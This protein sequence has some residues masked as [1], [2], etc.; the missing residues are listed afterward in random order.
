MKILARSLLQ[1]LNERLEIDLE[2]ND[3]IFRQILTAMKYMHENGIAHRD[4][5]PANILL[6]P[7]LTVKLIDFGIGK[8]LL[9]FCSF[10]H[11]MQVYLAFILLGCL[12]V[13]NSLLLLRVFICTFR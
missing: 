9:R 13:Q 12:E 10:T 5:K 11:D 4:I 8:V 7:D 1:Y 3:Y 2:I 6:E